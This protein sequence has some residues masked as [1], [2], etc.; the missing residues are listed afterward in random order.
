MEQKYIDMLECG[1]KRFPYI[2]HR[3]DIVKRSFNDSD[4]NSIEYIRR[5][6]NSFTE[7]DWK[8]I[9]DKNLKNLFVL[10]AF[11]DYENCPI[12]IKDNIVLSVLN[13]ISA[14]INKF[15]DKIEMKI[16]EKGL[17]LPLSDNVMQQIIAKDPQYIIRL[18]TTKHHHTDIPANDDYNDCL[19]KVFAKFVINNPEITEYGFD[20]T[21]M[22]DNNRLHAVLR[23]TFSTIND[24]DEILGFIDKMLLLNGFPIIK[25]ELYN[26]PLLD[27]TNTNDSKI[28]DTLLMD[29]ISYNKISQFNKTT[30]D[31]Y[32]ENFA[33]FNNMSL[34]KIENLKT[35]MNCRNSTPAIDYD[36]IERINDFNSNSK[37]NSVF[38]NNLEVFIYT[39]TSH[40]KL[41][42]KIKAMPL[43]NFERLLDTKNNFPVGFRSHYCHLV[44]NSIR[45]GINNGVHYDNDSSI[46]HGIKKYCSEEKL[47]DEDY[48][49]LIEQNQNSDIH[50]DLV[51]TT[52]TPR[53]VVNNIALKYKKMFSDYY[54]NEKTTATFLVAQFN[55]ACQDGLINEKMLPLLS[56]FISN[57]AHTFNAKMLSDNV[58]DN[59]LL[60]GHSTY[61]TTFEEFSIEELDKLKNVVGDI[62]YNSIKDK[63]QLKDQFLYNSILNHIDEAIY[64]NDK[65]NIR[66]IETVSTPILKKRTGKDKKVYR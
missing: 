19:Y 48:K 64:R 16:I 62:F 7:E 59:P 13:T 4:F 38:L 8:N 27:P 57:N 61:I 30:L 58:H 5:N 1:K 63:N 54:F 46:F 55:L 47:L 6:H 37:S 23:K 52:T 39:N 28:M 36:L 44:C 45:N 24:K 25:T 35:L 53:N 50:F 41:L 17:N 33:D 49:F 65:T 12:E 31:F 51:S 9:F 10:E 26:H 32:L 42:N 21:S 15:V 56:S 29:G 20:P 60:H 3:F 11:L 18:L 14:P 22:Y 43:E 34:Y 2:K 40:E 66:N